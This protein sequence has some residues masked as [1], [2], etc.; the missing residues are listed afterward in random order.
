MNMR[1]L[2]AWSLIAVSLSTVDAGAAA[3][4]HPQAPRW[5][6][7]RLSFAETGR[8]GAA[9]VYAENFARQPAPGPSDWGAVKALTAYC[10]DHKAGFEIKTDGGA[11]GYSF[12]GPAYGVTYQVDGEAL[13]S[14]TW[15]GS[16]T[17]N[18]ALFP[19]DVM[20]FL[21]ALPDD[22]VIAFKISDSFGREHD[23]AFRLRGIAAVRGLIARAC[24]RKT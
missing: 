18:A 1:S 10:R 23:A 22:G 12:W 11:W 21:Q 17:G 7:W 5:S 6:A 2:L 4:H 3:R 13:T 14:S 24:W 16:D 9:E 8:D 19:G 20:D 15:R